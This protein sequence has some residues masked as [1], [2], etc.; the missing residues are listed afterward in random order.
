MNLIL[1]EIA[2]GMRPL[3]T[4]YVATP[5]TIFELRRFL[6]ERPELMQDAEIHVKLPDE[7]PHVEKA[8]KNS[9]CCG[10]PTLNRIILTQNDLA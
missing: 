5:E 7:C 2:D 9:L 10:Q 6:Y 3:R 1:K 8:V 4:I